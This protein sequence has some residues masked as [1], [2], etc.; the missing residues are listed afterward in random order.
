MTSRL[1]DAQLVA[2]A[3]KLL[4]GDNWQQPTARLLGWPIDPRGQNRTVQR[5]KAAADAGEEYRIAPGVLAE[6]ATALQVRSDQAA[7]MAKTLKTA[8]EH[9]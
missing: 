6:L 8:S 5:I 7:A 1:N 4:F 3:G 2:H 9:P